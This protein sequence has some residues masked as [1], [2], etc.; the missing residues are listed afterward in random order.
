MHSSYSQ[1]IQHHVILLLWSPTTNYISVNLLQPFSCLD[2]Y[3]QGVRDDGPQTI[4]VLGRD[5]VVNE[6]SL[7]CDMTNGG[8]TQIGQ[9]E[10]WFD[11]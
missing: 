10:G 11:M 7:Y 9:V 2:L 8:W 3:N 6:V 5:G 4:A 1:S